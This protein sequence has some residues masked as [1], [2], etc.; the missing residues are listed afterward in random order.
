M[1]RKI[2][3]FIV[4]L[5]L[6]LV[7][8]LY[9]ESFAAW[10]D[11][12]GTESILLTALIATL[13]SLFPVI[14]YPIIGGILGAIYGPYLG[15]LVTWIGSSLASIV[16]FVFIR[17]GYQDLGQRILNRYTTLSKLNLLFERNAFMTIFLTRLIPIV[18]SIIVNVYSALSRVGFLTYTIASSIGKI[19]S[20]ILFATVGSTIVTN[21]IGLIYVAIFYGLFLLLVYA[22]Y[23]FFVRYTLKT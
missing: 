5:T 16:M 21:P 15:S 23:R 1:L 9:G 22:G 12:G 2:L 6:F 10:L 20:M 17:Y 7:A 19:P 18:P 4:L 11:A 3:V 13:L 8:L 14:P